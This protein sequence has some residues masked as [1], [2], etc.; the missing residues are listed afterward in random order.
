M[1]RPPVLTL[2]VLAVAV[3]ISIIT[4][5]VRARPISNIVE[6]VVAVGAPQNKA[7]ARVMYGAPTATTS[8]TMFEMGRV[9]SLIHI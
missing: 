8:S 5:V 3:S 9:L 7:T 1:R 2:F 4:V 6:L